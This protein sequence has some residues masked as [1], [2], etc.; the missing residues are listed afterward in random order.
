[1]AYGDFPTYTLISKASKRGNIWTNIQPF[2][3]NGVR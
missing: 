2:T 3:V 1:V